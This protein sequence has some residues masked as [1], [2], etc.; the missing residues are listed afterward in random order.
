MQKTGWEPTYCQGFLTSNCFNNCN[1]GKAC[2][3][4]WAAETK[5]AQWKTRCVFLCE[6]A[7]NESP[8]LGYAAPFDYVNT[9]LLLVDEKKNKYISQN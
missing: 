8:V 1:N 2:C 5:K 9:W 6:K 3:F 4:N 7:E